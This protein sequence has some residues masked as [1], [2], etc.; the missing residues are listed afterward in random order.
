MDVLIY[1]VC[2]I[3]IVYTTDHILVACGGSLQ[4][5]ENEFFYSASVLTLPLCCSCRAVMTSTN[6][7]FQREETNMFKNRK[8]HCILDQNN[9][10]SP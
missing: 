10:C 3:D 5:T 4:H 1:R 2:Y 9:V 7:A 8:V 6:T